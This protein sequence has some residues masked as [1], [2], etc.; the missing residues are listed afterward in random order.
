MSCLHKYWIKEF[1]RFFFIIQT[2][3]LMIFVIIDYLSRMDKFLS[4]DIGLG[5]GLWY[6]ILKLPFMF[7][8]LTPAAIL[9]STI[10]VFSLMNRNNELTIIK[11]AGI[12]AYYLV[13]P[14]L[15]CALVLALVMFFTGETLIPVTMSQANH[16]RYVELSKKNRMSVGKQDIWIKSDN[17]FIHISYFD[18]VNGSIAGVTIRSMG[19]DFAIQDRIFAEKGVYD[20]NGRWKLTDISR[21]TFEPSLKRYQAQ[22]ISKITL[23]L[24]ITPEDLGKA[25]KKT[26][27]MSFSQLRHYVNK[28]ESE[29][30][31]ATVYRVDM[32]AKPAFVCICI[33]M[34]LTGAALAYWV[35]FGVCLS[36]GYAQVLPPLAAAW[37]TNIIFM[38]AACLFLMTTQ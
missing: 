29:G 17:S 22:H 4:S 16:I 33:I 15:V 36:L 27:E 21:Q 23:P 10:V 19:K 34:A 18:P 11:S 37:T 12:S 35:M 13:R 38:C 6:V 30:Y 2:M 1:S 25:V 8:Q 28:V 14:A 26:D 24:K 3:V 7:V 20:N 5:R 9:L 32:H 31:D